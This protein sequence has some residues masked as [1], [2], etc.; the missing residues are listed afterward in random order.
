MNNIVTLSL[1]PFTFRILCRYFLHYLLCVIVVCLFCMSIEQ[2]KPNI[3]NMLQF[4]RHDILENL[5]V[6]I[7]IAYLTKHYRLLVTWFR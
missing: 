3:N 6:G 5:I 1:V 2:G 7:I 4:F